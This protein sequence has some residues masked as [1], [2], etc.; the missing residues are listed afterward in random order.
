LSYLCTASPDAL[1]F[2]LSQRQYEIR[3]RRAADNAQEESSKENNFLQEHLSRCSDPTLRQE[4]TQT[5]AFIT[6]AQA[7]MQRTPSQ[8]HTGQSVSNLDFSE[9][10][11][12]MIAILSYGAMSLPA[13]TTVGG[14]VAFYSY[15]ARYLALSAAVDIILG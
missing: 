10:S 5:R 12:L 15:L 11:P 13:C 3:L 4:E 9:W 1:F 6:R 14:F 2:R 7:K 8:E